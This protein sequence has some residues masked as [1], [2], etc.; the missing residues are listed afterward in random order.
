M[1]DPYSHL[2]KLNRKNAK[3]AN[4]MVTE[5]ARG[6]HAGNENMTPQGA[7]RKA[8]ETADQILAMLDTSSDEDDTITMDDDS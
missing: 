2:M 4:N 1:A 6:V 7:A 5:I 8:L 3:A